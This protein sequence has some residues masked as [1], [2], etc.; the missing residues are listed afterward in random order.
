LIG[1]CGANPI[2]DELPILLE[3]ELIRLIYCGC[4]LGG[5]SAFSLD[6]LAAVDK[7][8]GLETRSVLLALLLSNFFLYL[9]L[10]KSLPAS[11][12]RDLGASQTPI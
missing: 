3:S 5:A 12:L 6:R 8:G 1:L 10:F 9:V 4:S 7:L 2:A 11:M